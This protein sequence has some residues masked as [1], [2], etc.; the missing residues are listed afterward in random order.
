[1]EVVPGSVGAYRVRGAL[2]VPQ[3]EPGAVLTLD[4]AKLLG[5]ARQALARPLAGTQHRSG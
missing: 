2:L 5:V 4:G 1:M 3:A